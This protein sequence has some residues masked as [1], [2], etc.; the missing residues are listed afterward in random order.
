MAAKLAITLA[1]VHYIYAPKALLPQDFRG[2]QSIEHATQEAEGLISK[3]TAIT[4]ETIT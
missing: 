1:R 3:N 4:L 2:L